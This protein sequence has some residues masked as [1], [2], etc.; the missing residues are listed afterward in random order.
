MRDDPAI[1]ATGAGA[2]LLRDRSNVLM[3][4]RP[5][6]V[7]ARVSTTT[8]LV[9]QGTAWLGREITV[10]TRL[11]AAGAPVVRPSGE[12]D[13]GPTSSRAP[14]PRARSGSIRSSPGSGV[15]R[16][17]ERAFGDHAERLAD[18]PRDVPNAV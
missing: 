1:P 12:L 2:V 16:R 14:P 4:L 13:P 17:D 18:V 11:A 9:R 10:A 8:A 15:T 3:H 6:R 5:A 7:V